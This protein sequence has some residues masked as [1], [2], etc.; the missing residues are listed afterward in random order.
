MGRNTVNSWNVRTHWLRAT[1]NLASRGALRPPVWESQSSRRDPT[2]ELAQ[3][4]RQSSNKN[5]TVELSLRAPS[6]SPRLWIESTI[7]LPLTKRAKICVVHVLCRAHSFSALIRDL[8]KP[9]S[10]ASRAGGS[11][12]PE[13]ASQQMML[14]ALPWHA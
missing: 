1:A 3:S 10:D 11:E 9:Q 5:H 14:T 8:S 4:P 7:T 6:I 12:W 13:K 2:I